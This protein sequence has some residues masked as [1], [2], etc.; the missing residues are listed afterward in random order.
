MA[1]ESGALFQFGTTYEL[2]EF[3]VTQQIKVSQRMVEE[4]AEQQMIQRAI[5]G[6][7]EPK[8]ELAL[9]KIGRK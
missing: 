5:V 1:H 4:H 3:L 7:V 6:L 9:S 8:K 2:M